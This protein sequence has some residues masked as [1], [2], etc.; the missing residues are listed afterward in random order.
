M[1][2]EIHD[3][4]HNTDVVFLLGLDDLHPEG[5]EDR[6][7]LD[8]G[9]DF[10]GFFW[11]Q[12]DILTKRIP[13]IK[14]TLFMVADWTDRSNFPSGIFWPLRIIYSKR[15]S[16]THGFR[17]DDG[18]YLS[19]RKKLMA[20]LKKG[21]IVLSFHGLTHHNDEKK[22]AASQE[23]LGLSFEETTQR[24]K[25]MKSIVKKS[26]LPVENGFR[27]PGW[28]V[29]RELEKAL[30]QMGFGYMANSSDFVSPVSNAKTKGAGIKGNKVAAPTLSK[31]GLYNL[32]A[33]CF[34][35]QTERAVAIAKERGIVFAH[36]HIAKT[37]FGIKYVDKHF[38]KRIE[39]MV[40][41]IELQTHAKIW[42]ASPLEVIDFL[43]KKEQVTSKKISAKKVRITNNGDASITNLTVSVANKPFAIKKINK[44]SY[45]D[46]DPTSVTENKKVSVVLTVYNGEKY[47]EASLRSLARQSYTNTEIIVVNDGSTDKT[48]KVV[49][50][51]MKETGDTRIRLLNQKNGG[52]SNARNNGFKKTTGEIVTFCEDDAIYEKHYIERAARHFTSGNKKLAGVI[53]P[54]YVW[55]KNESLTTRIKDM[56]RRRNFHNYKP[57]TGW[58]YDRSLFQSIGMYDET[59]EL[60]EDIVPGTI[61]RK[62]GYR[63]V[64]EPEAR[65]LHREPADLRMYLRRKF[66]GGV[67][68]ALLQ[69]K[70]I[71]DSI[72]PPLYLFMLFIAVLG[73]ATLA[74]SK[75]ILIPFLLI[76][77]IILLLVIRMGSI[78]IGTKT[79]NEPLHIILFG[80]FYEYL[81]WSS[82]FAGYLYGLTMSETRI[83]HYLKGR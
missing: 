10:S 13:T 15:R 56:E 17:L 50:Q 81:W 31:N 42:F 21:T 53:G 45:V 83:V 27:A 28:G 61:L 32:N 24:L 12:M 23:F 2:I 70:H 71:R 11:Q 65:W 20:K 19:W 41:E 46:I 22:F 25:T 73:G 62:K 35:D 48:A 57:Q 14:V 76:V 64:Y 33:N 29:T 78:Q 60:V 18:K 1:K 67:G 36:G 9:K 54:H 66:K 39:T 51:F 4:P 43:R 55:N 8:F 63:F 68:M 77:G 49:E 3:Y 59:L 58:F 82:T 34:A 44:K 75:P 6:E 5:G 16:Y 37:I 38:V 80:V 26:G 30:V 69:K 40:Q 7:K 52:R 74:I 47:I 72:V 79:S